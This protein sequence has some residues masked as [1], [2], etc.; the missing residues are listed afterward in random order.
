MSNNELSLI[1]RTPNIECPACYDK[2]IHSKLE[3]KV[4]HLHAGE[5]VDNRNMENIKKKVKAT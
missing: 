4:Y 2:R 1:A 3:L 5:G